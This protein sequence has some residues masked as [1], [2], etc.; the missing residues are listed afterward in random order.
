[1]IGVN[2]SRIDTAYLEFNTSD[3]SP[4]EDD[5]NDREG[6]NSTGDVV[7]G[8]E[9]SGWNEEEDGDDYN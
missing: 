2:T 6:S 9:D 4:D 5:P 7:S 1:M 3:P 8:S